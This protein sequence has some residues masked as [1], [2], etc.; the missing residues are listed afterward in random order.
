MAAVRDDH[1]ALLSEL[2]LL[3]DAV[4][5]RVEGAVQQFVVAPGEAPHP[6]DDSAPGSAATPSG[7]AWCPLCAAAA[8]VRGEN[9]EL[10]TRLATKLAALIALL[11]EF[12][13]Q[14]L[15]ATGGSSPPEP[16]PD[17]PTRERPAFVP[18]SVNV[19]P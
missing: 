1:E 3:A 14:F 18:I 4:L 11:R 7:C 12:L 10:V 17:A 13:S 5:D 9:H 2:L 16:T 15:P 19:R 6:A 8:L